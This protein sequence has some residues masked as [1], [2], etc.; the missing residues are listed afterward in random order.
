MSLK[1]LVFGA[2]PDDCEIRAGGLAAK[3]VQAGGSVLF[4][5]L[6][7]GSAGHHEMSGRPL[8]ERR[9]KEAHNAAAILGAESLVLS[10][11]DGWLEANLENRR[12]V[13]RIVREF[14][15][16]VIVCPRLNDYH[17][18]HRYTSQLVQDACYMVMVPNVLP[19]VPTPAREPVVYYHLDGFTQPTT[20]APDLFI[21]TDDVVDQKIDAVLAHESQFFEWLPWI[22]GFLNDLPADPQERYDEVR[23]RERQRYVLDAHRFRDQLIATYGDVP[24]ERI[25]TIEAFQKSEYGGRLTAELSETLARLS[26]WGAG[27]D[28]EVSI[29]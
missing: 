16:D 14:S 25:E 11:P 17:P 29:G 20:F 10:N 27:S 15:P 19:D 8:V 24:G 5:S 9:A 21:V 13:I 23:H 1:L 3:I 18:D 28:G 12:A 22:K 7:D 26:A 6:T 4:A 2:H